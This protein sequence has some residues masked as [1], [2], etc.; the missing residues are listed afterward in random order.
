MCSLV[1]YIP[2]YCEKLYV[3]RIIERAFGQNRL[4]RLFNDFRALALVVIW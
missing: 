3:V 1:E 2:T 4:D